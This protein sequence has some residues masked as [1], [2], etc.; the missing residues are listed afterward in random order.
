ML[1]TVSAA[2]FLSLVCISLAKPTKL[3]I[4]D[5][6]NRA[7][8][9][10]VS[11]IVCNNENSEIQIERAY[12]LKRCM[13]PGPVEDIFKKCRG[14]EKHPLSSVCYVLTGIKMKFGTTKVHKETPEEK[15]KRK[16]GF[17]ECVRD[18]LDRASEAVKKAIAEFK[19]RR[20][21]TEGQEEVLTCMEKVLDLDT[22]E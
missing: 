16:H 10:N 9:K 11:Q 6:V 7:R 4:D 20:F 5:P 15:R 12:E 17:H 3:N 8:I 19:F 22:D 1:P 21:R 18:E 13:T 14:R 2:F